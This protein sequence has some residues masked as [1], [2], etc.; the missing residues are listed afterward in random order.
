[1]GKRAGAPDRGNRQQHRTT[2]LSLSR[3]RT[4][5]INT[6]LNDAE[7]KEKKYQNR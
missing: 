5:T 1:M 3:N 2:D 7:Q 4:K 6:G